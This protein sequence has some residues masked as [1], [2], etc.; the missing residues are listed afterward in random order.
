[1]DLLLLKAFMLSPGLAGRAEVEMVTK[2]TEVSFLLP[3]LPA[4]TGIHLKRSPD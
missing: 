4:A 2:T 3:P 1:M